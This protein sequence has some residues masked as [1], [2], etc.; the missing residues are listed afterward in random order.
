MLAAKSLGVPEIPHTSVHVFTGNNDVARGGV[1]DVFRA[2][3]TNEKSLP[4]Q[5]AIKK[6]RIQIY[7]EATKPLLQKAQWKLGRELEIWSALQHLA[8]PHPNLLPLLGVIESPDGLPSLVSEYCS[9]TLAAYLD[10]PENRPR[11][12]ELMVGTLKGLSYMHSLSVVHGDLK[13]VNILVTGAGVVK[14]CDFGHSRFSGNDSDHPSVSDASSRFH[15]TTR[16]MSPEF[17]QESKTKPT[18]FSDIW[19]FGC[20]ALEILSQLRPYHTIK[21]D[22]LVPGA[23][24]RGV[25]PSLKPEYPN[26]AGCLNDML[27]NVIKRCWYTNPFSRPSPDALLGWIDDLVKQE[28][29]NPLAITPQRPALEIGAELV[30]WP[31]KTKDFANESAR[32]QKELV[33]AQ[34]LANVWV[35]AAE[36]QDS[37]TMNTKSTIKFA[38][39][40]A[41]LTEGLGPSN[42]TIHPFHNALRWA[43]KERLD[44]QHRNIVEIL[45]IDTSCGNYPGIVLEYCSQ[46]NFVSYKH[47]MRQDEELY[48]TYMMQI[49]SG[50]EHLHTMI[51]PLAHGDLTPSNILVDAKGTL[52]LSAVSFARL[53]A[54]LPHTAQTMLPTDATISARYMSPELLQDDSWPTPASD[55]WAFGAIAFWIFSGLV[56]YPECKDETQVVAQICGGVPPNAQSQLANAQNLGGIPTPPGSLWLTNG[57]WAIILRCWSPETGHRLSATQILRK[58][59]DR[60]QMPEKTSMFSES[61]IVQGVE[62][63]TGSIKKLDDLGYGEVLGWSQGT[64]RGVYDWKGSRTLEVTLW[65]WRTTLSQGFFRRSI[66]VAV[67]GVQ[68]NYTANRFVYAARQSIRHELL[69]L[70]QLKHSNICSMLGF[71]QHNVSFAGV[72]V[73]VSEFCSNGTLN[74]YYLQR[75]HELDYGKRLRLIIALA[76]AVRYLHSEVSQG[77][78]CHGNLSM[79]TVLVDEK[80]TLKLGNFEFACQY[81]YSDNALEAPVIYAPPLAPAP[82]RWHAPEFF[83]SATDIGWPNP[84]L[85]ADLWALGC[86]VVAVVANRIPYADCDFPGA[87]SRII[88]GTKPYSQETCPLDVWDLVCPLWSNPPY[89]RTSSARVCD[90]LEGIQT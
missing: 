88:E 48:I 45:G 71:E 83:D 14:I 40:V 42:S 39:K 27:W 2:E 73:I 35:Y 41:C 47:K 32:F 75:F 82:T 25:V 33:S 9:A 50:L 36:N 65:S 49:L 64:W 12:V 72:P 34:R 60:P 43:V 66:Q 61:W 77:P 51:S 55:I 59:K 81:S 58:L 28:L 74:E 57:I 13:S 23:I 89:N 17:F 69:L 62:D 29:I 18:V 19:A 21:S 86:L 87:V 26:A 44:I 70:K 54:S 31:E 56:P 6:I 16:Y 46:G 1:A 11:R 90:V 78:I 37:S 3:Y 67:K 76:S 38:V 24:Q 68:G 22:H 4:I 30:A 7:G 8:E 79:D 15:A 80:G 20:I 10:N 84:T 85:Y 63:L 5:V 52:K 53:S